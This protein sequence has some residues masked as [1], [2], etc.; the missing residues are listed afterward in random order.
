MPKKNIFSLLVLKQNS[1]PNLGLFSACNH[2]A[3]VTDLYWV[4]IWQAPSLHAPSQPLASLSPRPVAQGGLAGGQHNSLGPGISCPLCHLS[5]QSS[6]TGERCHGKG[7]HRYEPGWFNMARQNYHRVRKR[8]MREQRN[9]AEQE[10][11]LLS[12][13]LFFLLLQPKSSFAIQ[14]LPWELHADG[15]RVA[16]WPM[17]PK[18]KKSPISFTQEIKRTGQHIIC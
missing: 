9:D 6:T 12:H 2:G 8:W 11:C 5:P 16:A 14:L 3:A 7:N 1:Y 18:I 15:F 17:E 13:E 4:P 10:K